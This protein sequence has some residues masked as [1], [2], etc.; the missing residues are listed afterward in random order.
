[1]LNLSFVPR[2][3]HSTTDIR[4]A[5]T[6]ADSLRTDLG[7]N[8]Q[9][10]T[11]DGSSSSNSESAIDN[12][13]VSD[14]SRSL[15]DAT[16]FFR[17]CSSC[18]DLFHETAF[19]C[20]QNQ[21]GE[22]SSHSS[23]SPIRS[24]FWAG[25]IQTS[26]SLK[27]PAHQTTTPTSID[28]SKETF[29]DALYST[30]FIPV[31][32]DQ[33]FLKPFSINPVANASLASR[34]KFQLITTDY[35]D[36]LA[37]VATSSDPPGM[38][39]R[40]LWAKLA[41]DLARSTSSLQA[42][43]RVSSENC[44]TILDLLEKLCALLLHIESDNFLISHFIGHAFNYLANLKQTQ[45][46]NTQTFNLLQSVLLQLRFISALLAPTQ[47]QY[48]ILN[49]FYKNITA[50]KLPINQDEVRQLGKYLSDAKTSL[51]PCR[52]LLMD[53][54]FFI[55][56]VLLSMDWPSSLDLSPV[57]VYY[58]TA[59]KQY[60]QD[61]SQSSI[62]DRLRHIFQNFFQSDIESLTTRTTYR[63]GPPPRCEPS[64]LSFPA[65]LQ[66]ALDYFHS[67]LQLPKI[68]EHSGDLS[69]YILFRNEID[70]KE[71]E[72]ADNLFKASQ[73][74]LSLLSSILPSKDIP[75]SLNTLNNAL[76]KFLDRSKLSSSN[77]GT[78]LLDIHP[79]LLP[80]FFEFLSPPS[81]KN[82]VLRTILPSPPSRFKLSQPLSAKFIEDIS[83]LYSI[84]PDINEQD[85]DQIA[86][87]SLSIAST[88]VHAASQSPA[89]RIDLLSASLS[90]PWMTG[91]ALLVRSSSDFDNNKNKLLVLYQQLQTFMSSHEP[92]SS[93]FGCRSLLPF[94]SF[95]GSAPFSKITLEKDA[96]ENCH[97]KESDLSQSVY[98]RY[99]G[100]RSQSYS[101][102]LTLRDDRFNPSS[103]LQQKVTNITFYVDLI[104]GLTI[105]QLS[106]THLFTA[107]STE[108]NTNTDRLPTLSISK[109]YFHSRHPRF[110]LCSPPLPYPPPSFIERKY[111]YTYIRSLLSILKRHHELHHHFLL[112]L[113]TEARKV[114]EE[115]IQF[116]PSDLTV[117]PHLTELLTTLIDI[118]TTHTPYFSQYF[119]RIPL[120]DAA[121]PTGVAQPPS[122]AED[123]ATSAESEITPART[124]KPSYEHHPLST[125]QSLV[126]LLP[127]PLKKLLEFLTETITTAD[128]SQETDFLLLINTTLYVMLVLIIRSPPE[129]NLTDEPEKSWPTNLPI[130]A[131]ISFLEEVKQSKFVPNFSL[132][133]EYKRFTKALSDNDKLSSSNKLLDKTL[134]SL[135][136]SK[137]RDSDEQQQHWTD[138]FQFPQHSKPPDTSFPSS[139]LSLPPSH[140][141]DQPVNGHNLARVLLG[142]HLDPSTSSYAS[143]RIDCYICLNCYTIFDTL[144]DPALSKTCA[145]TVQQHHKPDSL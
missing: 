114:L 46:A 103:N 81:F 67:E 131:F 141:T 54:V 32:N 87:S 137:R 72:A 7:I 132:Y 135:Y 29:L 22:S 117:I 121:Q 57:L 110:T 145:P 109:S 97:K 93:P 30:P 60:H 138:F 61:S 122:S 134:D 59:L 106:D 116:L 42:E 19:N 71:A 105:S 10:I 4:F 125:I 95:K 92:S 35:R 11:S 39:K 120:P 25:P 50:S 82:T 96:T 142:A 24:I 107:A 119:T 40:P 16:E 51:L 49:A 12:P 17:E 143:H 62:T 23:S 21:T 45:P 37:W 126:R 133:D 123:G 108:L 78:I 53:L 18:I 75:T 56:S 129:P 79:R 26:N 34:E 94:T 115:L 20:S 47:H 90:F 139:A 15:S 63:H 38:Y 100:L 52:R 58:S 101:T 113:I 89:L 41:T 83:R 112:A 111:K 76:T 136:A 74:R 140:Y 28:D 48:I 64:E 91:L 6:Y 144:S 2:T 5:A 55:L 33:S 88:L 68:T 3:L 102:N 118:Y 13:S 69:S 84:N 99:F 104:A 9:P 36:W 31:P 85:I 14:L 124:Q 27:D 77:E 130:S 66:P 43:E 73:I 128:S 65:G 70:T 1:M 80:W 44:D 127:T 98:Y 8:I 86:A